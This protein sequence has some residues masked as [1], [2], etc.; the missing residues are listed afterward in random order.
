MHYAR[1]KSG[2]HVAVKVLRPGIEQI[3]ATDFRALNIVARWTMAWKVIRRR[4]DVPALMDEFARTL[5]EE[6]DYEA[7]ASNAERFKALF[8]EDDRVYIPRIY[9][10]LSTKR[11]LT[12]EDVSSI[13]I[14]D[15][16]SIE[17]AGVDR[18]T[19]AQRLLD[20][21]LKMIF[22]FGF[23]HADPH[24][25]N[26]FIYPLPQNAMTNNPAQKEREFYIV[27]VDFGMVGHVSVSTK[28]SLR[29]AMIAVGLRDTQRIINAYQMLGVLLPGADLKRIEEAEAEILDMI[30]GKSVPEL[31]KMHPSEM[32]QVAIK[33]R[34]LL[35][36]MPFQ[37][38]QDFIYLGRAIAILSGICTQLDPSFNPWQ[39]VVRYAEKLVVQEAGS[40]IEAWVAEVVRFAQDCARIPVQLV[41]VLGKMQRGE[42]GVQLQGDSN[43]MAQLQRLEYGL[44]G[45]TQALVFCG[46]LIAGT[47][48]FLNSYLAIGIIAWGLAILAWLWM[49]L[50]RQ[51]SP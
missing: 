10:E 40:T 16:A 39:P 50:R 23:F 27:F 26:L 7:E 42:L 38:P 15:H 37:V 29:E 18:A 41:D 30:W 28:A 35:F 21:Y 51:P 4:A 9:R 1:L 25:G 8:A 17:S 3:V 22:E 14:S 12:M 45:I 44:S 46:L 20:I 33:Y 13:K 34:D 31:A 32:Q 48:L 36:E 11:V 49:V 19:A 2:Q 43:L 47:L 5:W 6:L 24:P